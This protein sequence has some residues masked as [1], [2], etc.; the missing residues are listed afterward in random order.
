MSVSSRAAVRF[1]R[2]NGLTLAFLAFFAVTLGA[3][4]VTGFM[5][6]NEELHEHDREVFSFGAY[7]TSGHFIE[8][9]FENW[10]SEFL[11]MGV[12]VVLTIHLRQRGSSES[13]S[14]DGEPEEV[15]EDPRLYEHDPRAPWP[16]RRGGLALALY[17]RSLTIAFFALFAG[18]SLLHAYGGMVHGNLER[19]FHGETPLGFGA[20]LGSSTFWF[21]SMQNWQSEFLSVAALVVLSIYLRQEGSSQ[22]KRV[23]A[24]HEETGD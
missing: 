3:Q 18:C 2:D 17:R 9:T 24:P 20:F 10:E 13:K 14:L 22:S 16:V 4:A 5:E 1:L 19:S 23:A 21:Q 6:L 8:A 12:F 7:L 15:D 11:Q